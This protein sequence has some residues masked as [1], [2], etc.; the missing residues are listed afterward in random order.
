MKTNDHFWW[1][2]FHEAAH[3]V[4]HRGRNFIDD[5]NGVGDDLEEEADRWAAE[6]LVGRQHVERLKVLRPRSNAA[7]KRFADEI[8]IHPGIIVGV[9]QHARLLPFSHLNGLKEKFQWM[10]KRD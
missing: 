5:Q 6:A 1:T 2:F 9:L 3:I 7:V 8:G 4:L 10:R